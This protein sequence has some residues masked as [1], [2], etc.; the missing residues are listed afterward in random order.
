MEAVHKY[1]SDWRKNSGI[2]ESKKRGRE[3]VVVWM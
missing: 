2:F 1:T 3:V